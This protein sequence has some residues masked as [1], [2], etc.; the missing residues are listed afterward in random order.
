[1]KEFLLKFPII[2][3]LY[4]KLVRKNNHEYDFFR[5]LF[6]RINKKKI[7]VLD[8][9]C[10]DSYILNYVGDYIDNYLGYDNNS[11]YLNQNKKKWKK[12]KFIY[13]DLK[14]FKKSHKIFKFKPNLI[15]MN[16][17]IHHLDNKLV[18]IINQVIKNRFNNAIFLSVD[19]VKN[20][21]KMINKLM[22]NFDRGKFIREKE[23]YKKVMT[24]HNSF[25]TDDFYKM[26]FLNIFHFRNINLKK[27]YFK[28]KLTLIN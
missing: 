26:S 5:Y 28:W 13:G 27:F 3:R 10:G 19:P 9:C 25:I 2:Y 4:Q 1:M 22:I 8:L 6:K 16:G 7:R 18:K 23:Q 14:N 20:K 17:A 12:F 11:F 15:F 24:N 21:N